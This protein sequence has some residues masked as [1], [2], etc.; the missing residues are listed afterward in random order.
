[1][2]R[3]GY[4]GFAAGFITPLIYR[5]FSA[6]ARSKPCWPASCDEVQEPQTSKSVENKM[7]IPVS[8]LMLASQLTI[9]VADEVPQF[10]MRRG[11]KID[12]NAVF[13]P[14][15]GM[16]GTIKR[17][18]DDEQNAKSKLEAQWASYIGSDRAMC[19]A[20][21]T[22][23]AATPPSYVDLLTCLQDQQLARKLPKN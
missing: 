4:A 12:S 3:A 7:L 8:I 6:A 21:T 18:M 9:A 17:C 22:S 19:L 5:T 14:N 2:E 16:A 13:D 11:C 1:L 15:A 10:D 20:S 23:D